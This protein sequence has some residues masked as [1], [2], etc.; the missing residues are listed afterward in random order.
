MVRRGVARQGEVLNMTGHGRAWPASDRHDRAGRG[1]ARRGAAGR[2]PA[3]RDG[4]A[5]CM[6]GRN[7]PPPPT[8]PNVSHRILPRHRRHHYA[9][10]DQQAINRA[11]GHTDEL[12]RTSKPAPAGGD[13]RQLRGI[14]VVGSAGGT[15][16]GTDPVQALLA[17]RS[18]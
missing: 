9:T 1:P 2:D 15:S 17:K 10:L 4:V 7:T 5:Q 8:L 6:A 14:P 12:Q 11:V 3:G 16:P 18:D 13:K